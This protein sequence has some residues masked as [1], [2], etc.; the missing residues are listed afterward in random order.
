MSE[1]NRIRS[2]TILSV[3]HKGMMVLAGDGQVTLGT[4]VIKDS[5]K[6][7]RRLYDGQILAGFAG[8][9]CRRFYPI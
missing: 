8:K 4:T 2:T 1:E 7:V 5:A 6:K 9:Y 3:F